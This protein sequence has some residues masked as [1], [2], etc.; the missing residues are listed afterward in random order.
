MG[1]KYLDKTG[2]TTLIKLIK[3]DMVNND[4]IVALEEAVVGIAED[5]VEQQE[6][7]DLKLNKSSKL[8]NLEIDALLK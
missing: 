5:N 1:N 2:L 4:T 7:I 3:K 8:S 6:Q